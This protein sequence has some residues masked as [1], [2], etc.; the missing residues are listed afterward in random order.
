M[1]S[2]TGLPTRPSISTNVSMVNLAV[3]LFTTSDT[4]GRDT[5]RIWALLHQLHLEQS[6]V[7]DVFA[8]RGMQTLGLGQRKTQ[9]HEEVRARLC[10]MP[11]F[12]VNGHFFSF[13]EFSDIHHSVNA[14]CVIDPNLS[15]TSSRIVERLPAGWLEPCLHL[16]Q[17]ETCFLTGLFGK[18]QKI[19]V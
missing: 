4:R 3:F 10:H 13:L 18:C 17:L 1:A 9:L 8:R 7:I 12:H 15:G 6:R 11:D 2:L 5:I 16:P 14:T 19:F